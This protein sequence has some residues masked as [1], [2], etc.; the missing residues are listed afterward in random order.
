MAGGY[1]GGFPADGIELC[2]R[3]SAGGQQVSCG[4]GGVEECGAGRGGGV[5]VWMVWGEFVF[6]GEEEEVRVGGC[7]RRESAEAGS[8]DGEFS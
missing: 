4:A 3:G 7:G 8:D 6:E 5:V 1:G 2:R